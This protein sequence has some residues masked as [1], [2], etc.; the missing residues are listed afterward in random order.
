LV[1]VEVSDIIGVARE[2]LLSLMPDYNNWPRLFN[3]HTSFR[4]IK[5]E[6]DSEYIEPGD[7]GYCKVTEIHRV[8]PPNEIYTEGFTPNWN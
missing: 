6:C 4:L 1:Q 8:M 3:N 7:K 5:R 2:G